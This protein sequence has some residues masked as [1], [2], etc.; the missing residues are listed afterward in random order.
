MTLRSKVLPFIGQSTREEQCYERS[1]EYN[2]LFMPYRQN[3]KWGQMLND[4]A[5][6]EEVAENIIRFV[7]L[8]SK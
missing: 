6:K 2:H 4:R 5:T 8:R 7:E 3:K 1:E